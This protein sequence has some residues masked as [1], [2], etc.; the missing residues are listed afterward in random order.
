MVNQEGIRNK[1]ILLMA[2]VAFVL[3][4]DQLTKLYIVSTF[5]LY[6]S[7]TILE[8]FF[9]ITYILNPGAAFG[10]F[11]GKAAGFRVPFFLFISFVASIGI[12][13][14][15]RSV[16]DRLVQIALS[17]IL[18]GAIGNMIDRARLGEVVDFI[19]VHWYN[20]HWPAFNVA[21]SAITIG[22]GLMIFDMFIKEKG[23][24]HKGRKGHKV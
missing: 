13:V 9:H 12:I 23:S 5:A 24:H 22:V 4:L 11:A 2:I 14:F 21:D 19:D 16:E 15:Y 18:G 17:L 3:F 1:Y 7:V 10:I 6:E 20:S 8:N